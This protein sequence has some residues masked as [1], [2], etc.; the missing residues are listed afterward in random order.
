MTHAMQ[1]CVYIYI[2]VNCILDFCSN[3]LY[4][5]ANADGSYWDLKAI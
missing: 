1:M 2:S 5:V 4:P 3:Y